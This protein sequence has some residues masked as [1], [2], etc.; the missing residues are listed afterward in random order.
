M[1][2]PFLLPSPLHIHETTDITHIAFYPTSWVQLPCLAPAI[3][4]ERWPQFC[5]SAI[6][7]NLFRILCGRL[8]RHRTS[9]RVHTDTPA[10]NI[11]STS[12][13]VA[14]SSYVSSPRCDPRYS[15]SEPSEFASATVP[16]PKKTAPLQI[17]ARAYSP[18]TLFSAPWRTL[19]ACIRRSKKP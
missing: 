10:L 7:L 16:V 1:Y 18:A 8:C 12:M 19:Y 9:T 11:R 3:A 14:Q 4:T 13:G 15:R 5:H 2:H 17:G 6:S